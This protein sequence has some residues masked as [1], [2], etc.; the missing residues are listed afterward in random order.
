MRVPTRYPPF[1]PDLKAFQL[2]WS[3]NPKLMGLYSPSLSLAFVHP[4]HS[5]LATSM[6]FQIG[7]CCIHTLLK[8]HVLSESKNGYL[9]SGIINPVNGNRLINNC[10]GVKGSYVEGQIVVTSARYIGW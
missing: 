7:S 10:G 2:L 5:V 6:Y 3:I 1:I 8:N 9:S 4:F